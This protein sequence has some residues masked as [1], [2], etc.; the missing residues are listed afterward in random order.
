M[1]KPGQA[2]K[3]KTSAGKANSRAVSKTGKSSP[4]AK[5]IN[6]VASWER[7]S[8]GGWVAGQASTLNPGSAEAE[9]RRRQG[10]KFKARKKHVIRPR[11]QKQRHPDTGQK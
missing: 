4:A 9:A 5:K 10:K 3:P 2:P 1:T 11:I 8:A 7:K 6:S